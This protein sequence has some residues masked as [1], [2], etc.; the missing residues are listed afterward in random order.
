MIMKSPNETAA[1]VH[2]FRFS[3]ARSRALTPVKLAEA[4]FGYAER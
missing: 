2:H 4:N 1:R 3:G